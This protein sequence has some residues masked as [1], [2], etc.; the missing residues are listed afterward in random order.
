MGDGTRSILLIVTSAHPVFLLRLIPMCR[1]AI[2]G[3]LLCCCWMVWSQPLGVSA[4]TRSEGISA[5]QL[6]ARLIEDAERV[7]LPTKFLKVLP[8]TFIHIEFDD[9]RTYA[10]E[11]HP[12]EHRMVFDRSLSFNAAGKELK[13]LI[14]MT[15]KQVEVLY[16]ELFHA[17][18]DYLAIVAGQSAEPGR[19][20]DEL[21]HFARVQQACRYGEV[22]ITP[23]VQRKNETELRSLTQAESWEALNETWAV[24]IGW[25]IWN[26][27][28]VQRKTDRSMFQ[29]QQQAGRWMR[30]FKNAF[31]NG[32]FRGYYVPEDQ[33]E[34]RVAQKR[35]LAQQ[36][37]LELGEAVVLMEQVLG[38]K[39]NFIDQLI[40]KFAPLQAS[41]CSSAGE[42][43]D[44]KARA[45]FSS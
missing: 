43:S 26:Q 34:R 9:L 32:E 15:P 25:A 29:D 37:Q 21:L 6:W 1:L 4:T 35:Y 27:L 38:F 19:H 45:E 31:E 7:Q 22:R 13:S 5:E 12:G 20:S 23:I 30:R 28:E 10:A 24:F 14:K 11:Y 40:A 3:V 8:P 44:K 16:H 41:S 36:S 18:V 39:K 2:R 33:D 17:Y 42:E